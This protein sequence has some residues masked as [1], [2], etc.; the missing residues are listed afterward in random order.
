MV[1]LAIFGAEAEWAGVA[2]RLRTTTL[3]DR[4]SACDAAVFLR[5]RSEDAPTIEECLRDGRPALLLPGDWPPLDALDRLTDAARRAG[6]HLSVVNPDR[7]LPSRRVLRQQLD[8]GHLG[9]PGMVRAHRW[10]AVGPHLAAGPV[11][12]LLRDVDVALWLMGNAPDVV[13][14][15]ERSLDNA[16]GTATQIHL[17]FPGGGMALLDHAATRA[18]A[19]GYAS[20]S[21]IG[22]S[23]AA[24]LDDH[25]NSQLVYRDSRDSRD[26]APR[27]VRVDEGNAHLAAAVE[28]YAGA[29]TGSTETSSGV[30]AWRLAL[31]V[32]AAARR[33]IAGGEAQSVARAAAMAPA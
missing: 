26:G 28:E 1:R 29:L 6:A 10:E 21:L 8:S 13:Y 14:A 23:G 32:V 25:Q 15:V 3:V 19:D 22:S 11:M 20:F 17:G 24:Y 33:A 2:Q 30:D 27:A 9:E 5:P 31:D 16:G 4:A 18:V 7:Y 12:R